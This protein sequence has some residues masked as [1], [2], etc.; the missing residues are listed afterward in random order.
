MQQCNG[1]KCNHVTSEQDRLLSP[2][3]YLAVFGGLFAA[4]TIFTC[5][6]FVLTSRKEE[7]NRKKV[8]GDMNYLFIGS[9]ESINSLSSVV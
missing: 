2:Q 3:T 4:T 1:K 5:L 7:C 9:T 6:A 8:P